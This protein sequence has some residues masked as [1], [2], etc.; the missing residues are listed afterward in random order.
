MG[1]TFKGTCHHLS[2]NVHC[3]IPGLLKYIALDSLNT[4]HCRSKQ[5]SFVEPYDKVHINCIKPIVCQNRRI[6]VMGNEQTGHIL[7]HNFLN[8][9][10]ICAAMHNTGLESWW[11]RAFQTIP[12]KS[13][14]YWK[15]LW[16]QRHSDTQPK[17]YSPSGV[18]DQFPT[19]L[20]IHSILTS[21]G[22]LIH[23]V[24]AFQNFFFDVKIQLNPM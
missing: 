2:V 7:A 5:W 11:L 10:W 20:N 4:V 16:S 6:L 1:W 3:L 15:L 22:F 13:Y 8:P 9:A 21:F 24:W 12:V 18:L 23:Y 17:H 14:V 19:C